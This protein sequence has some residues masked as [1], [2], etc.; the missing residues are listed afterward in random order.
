LISREYGSNF[1]LA[2][3]LT[4]VELTPDAPV[5]IAVDDLCLSCRRCALDCPPEAIGDEK[6][7][8]RGEKRWYVDF[9]KCVPYFVKTYGC[10]NCIEVCPWSE[11]G[12]GPA[13]SEQL[14]ARRQ[15]PRA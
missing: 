11:P 14:L 15:P 13:L 9:D 7:W 10:A 12:R 1:R 8:V 5:D 6:Q 4:E 3:V 2:T